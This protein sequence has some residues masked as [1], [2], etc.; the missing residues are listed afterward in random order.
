MIVMDIIKIKLDGL[1]C[2]ACA[3]KIED[4]LN[5]TSY[6]EN[7]VLNFVDQSVKISYS[8]ITKDELVENV[9]KL[10]NDIE[11]GITVYEENILAPTKSKVNVKLLRLVVGIILILFIFFTSF[12]FEIYLKV[13][14]FLL[15]GYDVIYKALR[16]IFT[17]DIFNENFLMSFAT[18]SA[19]AIGEVNEAIGVMLFYQIGEYFQDL[20]VDNSKKSIENLMDISIDTANIVKDDEVVDVKSADIKINDILVVKVGEK[21]PVDGVVIE[22]SSQ[23]DTSSL[24]GESVP[25]IVNEND[26]VLSGV[27]NLSEVIKIKA[28]KTYDDSTVAKI[29]ELVKDSAAHKGET[30][31][32]ITKFAKI[33]TPIVLFLAFLLVLIPTLINPDS[34]SIWFERSLIFLVVSCPCALVAS[35]PLTFFSG[36][37]YSSKRGILVKGSNYL[38]AVTNVSKIVFDKTGTIT[39]GN[40]NVVSFETNI[41]Q[42]QFFNI[43]YNAEKYSNHPIAKSI[44]GYIKKNFSVTNSDYNIEEVAGMGIRATNNNDVVLLGNSALLNSINHDKISS[45]GSCVYVAINNQYVGHIVVADK[46]KDEAK[47]AVANLKSQGI[48]TIMLTGDK[49]EEAE[50]I[51]NEVGIDKVYS[52]LLPHNK[53]EKLNDICNENDNLTIFVGD[54]INDAPVLKR[55]DIG[56][57]MGTIGSDAAIEASD[58]VIMN[59]NLNSISK[60]MSIA[61]NTVKIAKQNIAFALVVK[62]VILI[63]GAAGLAS[64]WLAIFADVGVT[65]LAVLNASRKK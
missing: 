65:L 4:K 23:L 51:A 20:A 59:D 24:T 38:Q 31:K 14:T 11:S 61:T 16:K 62:I 46:I 45:N 10:V 54:G 41:D 58:I 50:Y 26:N 2:S 52:S 32:F 48:E 63:L 12:N 13:A 33:Y 27:I 44:V 40:F 49:K 47:Q 43:V 18:V 15:F 39:K 64:M 25:I 34:F 60:L 55:S 21:I 36:L 56:I 3:A 22:G 57:S 37:G 28:T 29:I 6:V 8:D 30:E 1:N 53:V 42:E 35:I 5:T 17:K 7:A 19:F 9:Q